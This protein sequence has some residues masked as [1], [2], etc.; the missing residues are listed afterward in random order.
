MMKNRHMALVLATVMAVSPMSAM[1][2]PAANKPAVTVQ[3]DS[4][5]AENKKAASKSTA[6]K[7]TAS[8][9]AAKTVS[10]EEAKE[11]IKNI[12]SEVFGRVKKITDK[13]IT[14][15]TAVIQ[16][17]KQTEAAKSAEK[18]AD[19]VTQTAILTDK[20][21]KEELTLTGSEVTINLVKE[22]KADKADKDNKEKQNTP[23]IKEGSI[24][25]I[26]RDDQGN[27]ESVTIL[28]KATIKEDK[29][30]AKKADTKKS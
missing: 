18:K 25:K 30:D 16:E 3:K 17:E 15:E 5:S 9:V 29:A 22:D 12:E 20:E 1:A 19:K 10:K 14:L 27:A 7:S 4:K 11:A 23:E 2:A 28:E 26:T 21:Y 13:E 24:V 6:S 8:K